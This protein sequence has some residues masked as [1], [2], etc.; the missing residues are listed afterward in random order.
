MHVLHYKYSFQ[1]YFTL[2]CHSI[3]LYWCHYIFQFVTK[4]VLIFQIFTT[5]KIETNMLNAYFTS[6]IILSCIINEMVDSLTEYC[7]RSK[8]DSG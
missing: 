4:C 8:Q 2:D 3:S 6:I 1:V 5:N 7:F